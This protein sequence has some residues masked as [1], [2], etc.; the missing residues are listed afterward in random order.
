MHVDYF[1][2]SDPKKK[3]HRSWRGVLDTTLCDQVCHLLATG[4]WFSPCTLVSSS[5]KTKCYD[6]TEM[7]L[8]V[9]LNTINQTK[10]FSHFCFKFFV[11]RRI[12]RSCSGN[13]NK[14]T[15]E[16]IAKQIQP[17]IEL[18]KEMNDRMKTL[19]AKMSEITAV[20]QNNN[21]NSSHWIMLAIILTFQIFL[22]WCLR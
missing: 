20:N 21:N 9:A 1:R 5:N 15:E 17:I 13:R 19:N 6:I 14:L 12:Q 4:Q 2:I 11:D 7:L 3:A 10:V 8:K 22:Q 18:Q 16:S